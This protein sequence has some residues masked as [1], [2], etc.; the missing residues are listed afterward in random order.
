MRVFIA[1]DL[2]SEARREIEKFLKRLEKKHWKVKW[3]KPEKVHLTLAFLGSIK[4]EKLDLIKKTCQQVT[5]VTA[6]FIVSFKGFGCFPDFD[7]PRLVWLGLKGDLKSL[8]SLQKKLR[9]QLKDLGF[10]TE[11]RPFKPHLTLGRIKRARVRERREIGRQIKALRKIDFKS[12]WLVDKLVL[13][14]SKCLP[15]GSV[16]KKIKEFTFGNL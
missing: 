15:E 12:Q 13:Y 1:L 11:K 6:S 7:F 5:K 2:T 16:Y 8:A 14:E 10:K 9:D 4:E 3:E